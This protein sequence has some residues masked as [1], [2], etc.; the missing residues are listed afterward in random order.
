MN[1]ATST[2]DTQ[3]DSTN[4]QEDITYLLGQCPE[5]AMGLLLSIDHK[6]Y[7]HIYFNV[8]NAAYRISMGTA[9]ETEGTEHKYMLVFSRVL[10]RANNPA[11]TQSEKPRCLSKRRAKE[12]YR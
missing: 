1:L 3:S 8:K 4:G 6:C 10:L 2:N 5:I 12:R 7:E 9:R 11:P